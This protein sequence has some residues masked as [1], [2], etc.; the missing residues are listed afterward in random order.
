MINYMLFSD[1]NVPKMYSHLHRIL[2]EA[3]NQEKF[4]YEE[5]EICF[6]GVEDVT[7]IKFKDIDI[8]YV[9]E[10]FIKINFADNVWLCPYD[11]ISDIWIEHSYIDEAQTTF[12]DYEY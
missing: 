10:D 2:K 11:K 4:P 6:R 5:H 3:L 1:E 7:V 8:V 9:A 12:D